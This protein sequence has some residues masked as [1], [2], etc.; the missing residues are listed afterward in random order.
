MALMQ[1]S[2]R[3]RLRKERRRGTRE[4][5]DDEKRNVMCAMR[6]ND[7]GWESN[8]KLDL[9]THVVVDAALS[10]RA[11]K[12]KNRA[13]SDSADQSGSN[14]SHRKITVTKHML[15]GIALEMVEA[16]CV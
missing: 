1:Q 10:L 14:K 7:G 3:I 13:N 5:E 2:K 8:T 6:C 9:V 11:S 12:L 16:C 15:A 4:E